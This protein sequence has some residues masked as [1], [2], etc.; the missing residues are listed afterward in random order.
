MWSMGSAGSMPPAGSPTAR[1]PAFWTG[2]RVTVT[3]TAGVVIACRDPG[4]MVTVPARPCIAIPAALRRRCGLRAGD[5]V[6]LAA[7]PGKG[8]LA[9]YTFT[10]VH[11]AIR[12]HSPFPPGE[13]GQP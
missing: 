3:A 8:T 7:V 2:T 11:E 6:L 4:G 9:A 12:A 5:L 13:G 1:S 10:V